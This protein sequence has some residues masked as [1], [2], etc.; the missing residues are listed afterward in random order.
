MLEYPI[1]IPPTENVAFYIHSDCNN[2]RGLKYRS[3]KYGIV[4]EDE[5]IVITHGYAHTSCVPFHS[6]YGWFR[7]CRVLSGSI[8]YDALPIRWSNYTHDQFPEHFQQSI[9]CIQKSLG[10]KKYYTKWL[11]EEIIA[12]IP[13]DWWG[14]DKT[15]KE[16]LK[17]IDKTPKANTRPYNHYYSSNFY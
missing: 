2:D 13:F 17:S 12:F 10:R 1:V 6:N 8:F 15:K 16:F 9:D 3:C 14:L 4:L 7:E 5:N 11:I